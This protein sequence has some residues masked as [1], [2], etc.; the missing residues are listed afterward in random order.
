M[1]YQHI[2]QKI[3]CIDILNT[4][5]KDWVQQAHRVLL[6]H[7]IKTSVL[8]PYVDKKGKVPPKYT[9]R[10]YWKQPLDQYQIFRNSIEYWGIVHYLLPKKYNVL[11]EFTSNQINGNKPI[12]QK[13]LSGK[14][15]SLG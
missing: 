4:V 5:E 1:N 3:I 11:C 7:N 14:Y 15:D 10:L 2:K 6:K 12:I 13:P 8:G 9:L